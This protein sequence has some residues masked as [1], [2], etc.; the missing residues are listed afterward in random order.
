MYICSFKLTL[1]GVVFYACQSCFHVS[2][3]T[4]LLR[5]LCSNIQTI[6]CPFANIHADY[7]FISMIVTDSIM[8]EI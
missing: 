2:S 8:K 3:L 7:Y 1:I 6:G 4:L 5:H